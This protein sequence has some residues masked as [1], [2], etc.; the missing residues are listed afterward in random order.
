MKSISG[1]TSHKNKIGNK[2]MLL[3]LALG[4]L[5]VSTSPISPF[6]LVKPAMAKKLITTADI[7]DDA[8]TSPKIK[9][10]EVKTSDIEDSTITGNDVSPAFMIR[11]TLNDDDAGHVQNWNPNGIIR[12][13]D[14]SDDDISG[15]ENSVFVSIM[16]KDPPGGTFPP[17]CSV[18]GMNTAA[19]FWYIICDDAPVD[20]SKLDYIITKLPANVATSTAS[21]SSSSSSMP[22]I[23]SPFNSLGEH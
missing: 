4:L 2:V 11:K 16:M 18:R 15:D 14:I 10:G 20:G 3:S 22:T 23:S 1:I 13:F 6:E 8:V 19:G 17:V 5:I 9:D 21:A 7:A 12:T